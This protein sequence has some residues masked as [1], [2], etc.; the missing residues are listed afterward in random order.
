MIEREHLIADIIQAEWRMFQNVQNA[1]GRAPCQDDTQTFRIMRESQS[2]GWSDEML[3]SYF[4]DLKT[5][6]KEGRNLLTEKY[7]RMMKST[8]PAEYARIESLLP[9][10][11]AQVT[12]LI[13]RITVVFL[14]WE[15]ELSQKFPHVLAKGR[16]IFST[17][18]S[19][20]SVSL[21]TYLRGELATYSRKTLE[22][23]WANVEK[24]KAAGI[25]G[26]AI[27]LTHIVKQ[28]GYN[29]LEEANERLKP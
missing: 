6:E 14:D 10:L 3:E 20:V 23:Y 4:D 26:S 5:A 1:G 22:L 28:Y 19:P 15:R 24:Q 21:E 8:S 9:P 12:D 11:D 17:Q 18:D 27:T 7:A 25:N 2:A 16:P 29:S 13:D